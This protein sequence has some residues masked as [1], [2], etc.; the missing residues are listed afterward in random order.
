MILFSHLAKRNINKLLKIM[1]IE[2]C[3]TILIGQENIKL[4]ITGFLQ[5]QC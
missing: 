4:T 1:T 5:G 2:V 3:G